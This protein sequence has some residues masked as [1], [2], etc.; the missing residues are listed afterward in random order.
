MTCCDA[1]AGK[2][3]KEEE[4]EDEPKEASSYFSGRRKIPRW[5]PLTRFLLRGYVLYPSLLRYCLSSVVSAAASGHRADVRTTVLAG[6]VRT[7]CS[8]ML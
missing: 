8:D 5:F 2:E 7:E 1:K 4:E 3:E 6:Q